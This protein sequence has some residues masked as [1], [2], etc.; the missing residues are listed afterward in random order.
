MAELLVQEAL[1]KFQDRVAS[2][3]QTIDVVDALLEFGQASP[4]SVP[5]EGT[6]L[7]KVVGEIR[8]AGLQP[9]LNGSVLLLAAVLEQFVTDTIVEFSDN[10]P[11]VVPKYEDLPERIR[12]NN[13]QMTGQAIGDGRY[14]NR[15]EDYELPRLV[16]NLRNCQA[17][18]V[19]YVLNGEAL[20]LHNRNLNP[21]TMSQL[22]GRLGIRNLWDK[23]GSAEA[24]RQWAIQENAVPSESIART[25]LDELIQARNQI[26]HSAGN[27][28]PGS[29]VVRNFLRYETALAKSLVEVFA[30]YANVLLTQNP[31]P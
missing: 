30:D 31:K 13:E 22:M 4:E 18:E 29:N 28:N 12:S 7:H 17:G 8:Q 19:P 21:D 9:V 23:I 5:S 16:E 3:E 2:I 20:A 25:R 11:N 24:L 26:A 6:R 10:L 15:F 27:A 1:I 14:R